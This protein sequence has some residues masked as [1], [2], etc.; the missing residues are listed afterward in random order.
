MMLLW[1]AGLA[2][3]AAAVAALLLRP[4]PPAAERP[5]PATVAP[6]PLGL[7]AASAA[8]APSAQAALRTASTPGG[9]ATPGPRPIGAEGFGPHLDQAHAGNDP[10]AAWEAVLWMRRCAN[11]E[12]RR[13]VS[14]DLRNQGFAPE[15]MTQ[16]IIDIDAEARRCQT[17]TP[18]HRTL[19]APLALRAMRAGV[20]EAASAY[21][22]AVAPGD[23]TPSER[24]E[25]AEALRRDAR[26][27][28]DTGL[29]AAA[30]AHPGWA[31]SDEERL[32]FLLAATQL[33]RPMMTLD[34]ALQMIPLGQVPLKNRPSPEQI[35]AALQ[36]SR[37]WVAE[38]R[39]DARP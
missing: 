2:A 29:L 19:L 39:P 30:V 24:A 17:I 1:M 4:L 5:A 18:A 14:E 23:L 37:Q 9:L 33:P 12:N 8:S 34:T 6:L 15:F 22:D 7:P 36:A 3:G 25:V 38:V 10:Q 16:R 32:L 31:L 13:Q 20:P 21:A 28:R 11:N 27:G 26:S 35:A